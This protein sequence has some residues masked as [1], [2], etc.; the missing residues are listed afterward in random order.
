MKKNV[1]RFLAL[2]MAGTMAVGMAACGSDEKGKDAKPPTPAAKTE[3]E[4]VQAPAADE[5]SSD[6]EERSTKITMST[7][8]TNDSQLAP[9][10][11]YVEGAIEDKF[12][13]V[14]FEFKIYTDRQN[15]M[16]E[17][18][19]GGGPDILDL[20]GPTDVVEFAE[21]EKAVD[22]SAYAEKFDWKN[23]ISEWAYDTSV[24]HDKLYSLPAGFEGMGMY[25]NLGVMEEHGWQVPKNLEELESLM[26]EIKDAGLIPISFGN[27]N[28]QGAVDHLY[29]TM[30]SCLSGP[31]VVKKAINGEIPFDDPKMVAAIDKLKEWWDNGYISDQASQTITQDDQMAFF[32]EGRAVMSICGTWWA[33]QLVQTYPDCNWTFEMM[34]VM[35]DEAGQLF[36][37]A[38]GESYVI[39]ANSK[40]PD[41][42][43]E[44]LNLLYTDMD[45]F[46][47]AVN[48]GALQP[49]PIEAFDFKKLEGL[50][51]KVL[52][53]NEVMATASID[54]NI[55]YCSWS[56][57]PAAARTYMN[58]NMDGV[59]LGSM[60]PADY[61]KNTQEYIDE[62]LEKGTTPVLP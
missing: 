26:K 7:Y 2:C 48:N 23:V 60:S 47:A 3:T 8:L 19:G 32:A 53:T 1:K 30:L 28:Y 61:M 11:E 25:Y 29:S 51:E 27:A 17:V 54:G 43:A 39:S 15:M 18:A 55:G 57:W 24:Y 56:F 59:F 20:D 37:L 33:S 45:T 14:D 5:G 44:I 36:P 31:E 50:D 4:D 46:Y 13:D 9:L 12:P 10:K 52:H 6:T 22:M 40:N 35:N 42:C 41:I 49:F 16:V 38:V 62:G 34:P 58:E 21:A